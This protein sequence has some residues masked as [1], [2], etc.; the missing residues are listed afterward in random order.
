MKSTS[1][2]ESPVISPS[3]SR[4]EPSALLQRFKSIRETT[5]RICEPL[6][7]EDYVVQTM[8]D[9]SPTKWH[10]GHT[11]WFFETLI[12]KVHD[13]AYRPLD[14]TYA[15]IFNSYYNSLGEQFPRPCRGHLSR[16]TVQQVYAY[17]HH[18]NDGMERLLARAES[19]EF[20][21]I[22]N[23]V[24]IGL[25]HEQQHQ[26][27]ILTD[28][29]NVLSVNPMRP[30]YRT[31]VK[32]L[33]SQV[34]PMDWFTYPE[35]QRQIGHEGPGFAYDN[36]TP[37]H[38]VVVGAFRLASRLVTNGEYLEFINDGGYERPELWLSDG[39]SARNEQQWRGPLYWESRGDRWLQFSLGGWNEVNPAE[40]VCHV[41]YYEADAY[42]R[43]KGMWLP[44][45]AAWEVAA[46]DLPVEGNLLEEAAFQPQPAVPAG[47]QPALMQ[48][49]GDVWE[50]TCSPYMRYP[51]FRPAEGSLGEYN[52]KFMANQ[53][54]L[55][56]GSCVT[57]KTHIRATYRNFMPPG[58]RW[59]F[60]GIRLSREVQS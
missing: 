1:T 24:Q 53:M 5:E 26:E 36:E 20:V 44:T 28:I 6:A 50:W 47:A 42:A 51:G 54:V 11:S 13:A 34:P 3:A 60:S 12:L 18:V 30:I 10:L 7:I 46:R 2:L 57:P 32:P 52:A 14:D 9:V 23:L 35:A 33:Q 58:A 31:R 29:K 15:Y 38:P 16:P 55:R 19:S 41:S 8:P 59:Q 56:G 37:R 4:L 49:Y 27:L 40:P 43:W 22:G 25:H 21:Q 39:W 48:M 17:R 45:E